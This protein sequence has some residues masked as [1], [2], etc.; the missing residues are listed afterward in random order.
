MLPPAVT[1]AVVV[2]IGLKLATVATQTYFPADQWMGLLTA[3]FVIGVSVLAKGF[4]SRVAIVT[5]LVFG[6]AVSFFADRIFGRIQQCSGT[7][8]HEAFRDRPPPPTRRTSG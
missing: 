6:Y 3:A 4:F 2:L 5:S 1:G 8:C 7:D